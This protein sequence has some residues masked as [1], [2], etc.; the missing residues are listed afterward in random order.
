MRSFFKAMYRL[1]R[2]ITVGPLLLL[3]GFNHGLDSRFYIEKSQYYKELLQC[4]F[5]QKVLRI[6]SH[7]PWPVHFSSVFVNPQN[8]KFDKAYVRNFMA[9]AC[10]WQAAS[11]IIFRGSFLVAQGVGF[12][13]QNHDNYDLASHVQSS[14]IIIGDN[15]LLALGCSILSGVELGDNTIVAAGAVVSR[16]FPDGN[17]VLAGVPAKIVKQLD[18]ESISKCNADD[19]WLK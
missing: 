5:F 9:A 11:Q 2:R 10:Y 3:Y 18:G 8:I 4:L 6:N 7:V 12:V 17:C 14:P 16:S 15:C 19:F 1:F 13:S